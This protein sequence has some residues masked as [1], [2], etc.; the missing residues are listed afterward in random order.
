[1][2]KKILVVEDE[3]SILELIRFNLSKEG[4]NISTALDGEEAVTKISKD[5]P[6]LIVLDLMLPKLDG[7]E[8]CKRIREN[9]GYNVYIIMLT[10]K[11]EEID[12]IVGLEVGA[13]DYMTKPFSPKELSVRIKAAF[14]RLDYKMSNSNYLVN[15]DFEID[16][17]QYSCRYKGKR[18]SLTPKQ[19]TLLTYLVENEEKVC[20]REELL[21]KVWGYDYLGDS[22][23]VDVHVRQIRQVLLKETDGEEPIPIKTLRGVGY[24]YKRSK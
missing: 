16:K 20:S 11:G 24:S 22:R 19:F 6:D 23:T 10:A 14:R 17:E 3:N 13:D 1:M 8:V 12:K 4:Y 5:K 7:I 15:G 2:N 18:L 9:H 21:S